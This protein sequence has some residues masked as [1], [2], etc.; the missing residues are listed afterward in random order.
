MTKQKVL[1]IILSVLFIYS[2]NAQ[3]SKDITVLTIGKEKISLAEFERIYNK[4]RDIENSS[5]DNSSKSVED[6]M[7]LFINFKLKVIEAQALG[8]DTTQK[9]LNELNGYKKQLAAPYLTDESVFDNLVKEAYNRMQ[10]EVSVSHIMIKL[11]KNASPKDTLEAFNKAITVYNKLKQ[12]EDFTKLAKEYS[13]DPS[14]KQNEGNLGYFTVFRMVYPFENAA[15][16]TPVGEFSK[17]VRTRFGYHIIKVND[18]RKAKGRIK[19]AHIMVFTPK[20]MTE[21]DLQKA[22]TKIDSL[23]QLVTNGSDFAEVAKAF[24]EDKGTA[25]KGGELREF[26]TGEMVPEFEQEA[27]KLTQDGQISEPVKTAYGWHIIKRLSLKGVGSF[28]DEQKNIENKV[29]RTGRT[30]KSKDIFITGLK[31]EYDFKQKKPVSDFYSVVDSTIFE[32]EWSADK[33]SGLSKKFFQYAKEKVN[34]QEFANYLAEKQ[35]KI[36]PIPIQNYVDNQ[37]K[38][39]VEEKLLEYEKSKLEEKYPDYK[40]LA[41]EYHDGILLFDITN[42]KVWEK[43][44]KDTTGLEAF[45]QKNKENYKWEKRTEAV[46]YSCK[47]KEI[48][49]QTMKLA[50]KRVKDNLTEEEI[51]EKINADQKDLLRIQ[52]D[53]FEEGVSAYVD[54]FSDNK[55][56]TEIFEDKGRFIFVEIVDFLAPSIKELEEAKGLITSDYQDY[57]EKEWVKELRKKYSFEVNKSA[58]SKVK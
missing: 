51:L 26:G 5:I 39:F 6:Y 7:E 40:Y 17:P 1:L 45:Y 27:F 33:A 13:E 49:E 53:K 44:I 10:H 54:K 32:G 28:E 8:M 25:T 38:T 41:K 2:A 48:A 35:R 57:L 55:G 21:E 34:Q 46:I 29:R 56:F 47:T 52:H 42:Q 24:S 23:Y 11:A 15:F 19:V 4:N 43:A 20:D 9:F 58:L 18:K 16:N 37:F 3:E 12:G 30:S 36:S 22:K 50:K 31:K 14:V